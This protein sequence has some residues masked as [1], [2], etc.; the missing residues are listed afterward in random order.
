[1]ARRGGISSAVEAAVRKFENALTGRGAAGAL[2]VTIFDD[3][4][5]NG[6]GL[7]RIFEAFDLTMREIPEVLASIVPEVR[8]AH[9][10]TFASEGSA[11]RGAWSPLAPATLAERARLGYGPGPILKRTGA[12]EAHVLNAPVKITRRGNT[13][14]LRIEPDVNVGGVPKYRALALG[15]PATNLPPRPMVTVGSSSA[16]KITSTLQRALRAR[17]AARGL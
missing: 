6:K 16:V 13:V 11:G 9:A 3:S 8:A 5:A 7:D 17:A 15:N 4:K 2:R 14:E 12:L 1:M 10:R